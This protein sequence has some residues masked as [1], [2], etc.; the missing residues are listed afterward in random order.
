MRS[1]VYIPSRLSNTY[2]AISLYLEMAKYLSQ[3]AESF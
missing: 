3:D 2:S 1:V